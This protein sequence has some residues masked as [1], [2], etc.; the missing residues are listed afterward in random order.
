MHARLCEHGYGESIAC[1]YVR[2]C[3]GTHSYLVAFL[4]RGGRFNGQT[5]VLDKILSSWAWVHMCAKSAAAD[6]T[7]F[8]DL[9]EYY[10]PSTRSA[11]KAVV[12]Y[13]RY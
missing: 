1:V 13:M 5:F 4:L 9:P 6:F 10:D 2:V 12:V 11:E 7:S 8:T 3:Q